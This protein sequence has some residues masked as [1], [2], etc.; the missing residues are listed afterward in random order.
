VF[1]KPETITI[2]KRKSYVI[3]SKF[4]YNLTFELKQRDMDK[5]DVDD[6]DG[7]VDSMINPA[8]LYE[9]S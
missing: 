2:L 7:L 9:Y 4:S 5:R 1:L 3:A 8:V 6:P